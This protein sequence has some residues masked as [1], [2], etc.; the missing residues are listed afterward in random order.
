MATE[1]WSD[2]VG[3]EHTPRREQRNIVA[4]V[5]D[6]CF[7]SSYTSAC[8]LHCCWVPRARC[9]AG[10]GEGG[11]EGEG[12]LF[13]EDG[14]ER[15]TET[16]AAGGWRTLTADQLIRGLVRGGGADLARLI[17][18]VQSVILVE[19]P[20]RGGRGSMRQ[21]ESGR[22]HV[23]LLLKHNKRKTLH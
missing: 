18:T 5:N 1:R 12:Q 6:H 2:V 10:R 7:N 23:I 3:S 13:V 8:T 16:P 17:V 15:E 9:I 19:E 4:P 14:R 11:G 20:L 22:L 21:Q